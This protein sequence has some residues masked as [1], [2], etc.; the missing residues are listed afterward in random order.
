MLFQIDMKILCCANCGISFGITTDYENRRRDDH[1][2]FYC[3]SGHV[4]VFNG[5][6]TSEKRA[7]EAESEAMQAQAKLNEERH[8]RLVA[9]KA[10][11]KEASKRKRLEKRVS[12]GVCPC[13]NRTFEDLAK[14]M[15]TKHKEYGISAGTAKK[16][17]TGRKDDE[18]MAVQ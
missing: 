4:N 12:A 8:L 7:R 1:R 15:S 2:S 6:S 5:P 11:Q 3:P 18:T 10:L 13:C 17:I 9:E 14:H 16:Q